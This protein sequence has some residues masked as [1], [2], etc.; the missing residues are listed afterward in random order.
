MMRRTSISDLVIPFA[1]IAAV[2][3]LLLWATYSSLPP[4]QWFIAVPIAA[5]AIT[6]A[7][8][9]RR[10]RAAVRHKFGAKPMT[11]LAVARGVALGKASALVG[12]AVAGAALALVIKVTPDAQRTSAAQHDLWVGS[13]GFVVSAGLVA[14]GLALE[15]AGI[16]PGHDHSGGH[17]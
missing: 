8:V 10:V 1:I 14:A 17:R 2:G 15:R 7:I 12:S 16:D 3:Y 13:A 5:L 9:A 11:A 6:E 4:F